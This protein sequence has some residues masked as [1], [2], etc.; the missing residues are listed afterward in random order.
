MFINHTN[1]PSQDWSLE[2]REIAMSYGTIVDIPFPNIDPH[3]TQHEIDA[4]VQGY[5][6]RIMSLHPNAVLCQGEFVYCHAVVERLL[7]AGITVVAATSQRVVDE[8]YV[9]G[10]SHKTVRFEFVQF[11]EYYH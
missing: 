11:R 9:D 5:T 6:E 4:L 3:A 8:F 7:V 1:H 2:Q 10:V